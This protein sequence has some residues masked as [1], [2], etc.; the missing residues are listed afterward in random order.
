VTKTDPGERA[1][2]ISLVLVEADRDGFR[3]GRN[4]EKLGMKAQ[5]T[6]ELFFDGCRQHRRQ[7][8][9]NNS[10]GDGQYQDGHRT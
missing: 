10:Q 7:Y 1:K 3:K 4:L 6:S 8:G 5:D 9:G 2:G